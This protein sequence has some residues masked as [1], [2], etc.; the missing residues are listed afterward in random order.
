MAIS[1]GECT[2][3][4]RWLL[5][6]IRELQKLNRDD[7]ARFHVDTNGSILTRD[8]ID[9]LVDAG[10][11]DI[12]ID[13]KSL[14]VETFIKITAVQPKQLAK[15]YLETAWA[16]VKYILDNYQEKLYLGVGIPYNKALCSMEELA[17]MAEKLAAWEPRLQVCALD[18]RGEFRR[19]GVLRKPSYREMVKV[20]KCLRAA[21]LKT[22]LCKTEYGHIGPEEPAVMFL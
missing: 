18:Y 10:V 22:V 20:W 8:Y 2:L 1:G 3:N 17:K 21:G 15:K 19:E 6:Y 11:T 5:Q 14:R 7:A 9:E 4:R 13:L 16:A 12:G